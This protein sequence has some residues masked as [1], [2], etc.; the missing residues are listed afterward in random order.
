MDHDPAVAP[1]A[2]LR[3]ANISAWSAADCVIESAEGRI[4][5][6]M[7]VVACTSSE[8]AMRSLFLSAAERLLLDTDGP[9]PMAR[10]VTDLVELFRALR[11]SP[12]SS[13][14]GFWGELYVIRAA[15]D[16]DLLLEAWHGDPNEV[17]DFGTPTARLEVKTSVSDRRHHFS[18]EQVTPPDGV[19]AAIVS[20]L[21]RSAVAGPSIL[22]LLTEIAGRSARGDTSSFLFSALA[23]ALGSDALHIAES[24][25]DDA[26]AASTISVYDAWSVPRPGAIPSQVAAVKFVSD[27]TGLS[28]LPVAAWELL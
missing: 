20:V 11:N 18:L 2:D 12:K 15:P 4:R 13:V 1:T 8:P 14:V 17:F 5:R 10:V 9:G 27:L 28:S 25:F 19:T 16:V 6:S 3:L 22:D 7:D 24:R 23:D 21:T 26:L